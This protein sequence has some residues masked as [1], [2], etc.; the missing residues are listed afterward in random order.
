[1]K[2]TIVGA[3]T[4]IDY[5][6]WKPFMEWD[7]PTHWTAWNAYGAG[8]DEILFR[9]KADGTYLRYHNDI[10]GNVTALL[11]MN[12]YGL[13]HYTYDAFGSP[14]VTNWDGTNSRKYSNYGN[15]FMFQ[16]REYF[17]E[18]GIYDYRNRFYHPSIG[19]FLQTDPK[20]FDAGDMNLF[21]YC[22]DDPV[23]KSDPMGLDFE[24]RNGSVA[25][26]ASF[27]TAIS[28]ISHDSQMAGYIGV[29]RQ[30]NI[31]IFF[32]HDF[33]N[34]IG[35]KNELKF[36]P[37]HG[38][39]LT[40]G[41]QSPALILA[42]EFKHLYDQITNRK[43]YDHNLA[44]GVKRLGPNEPTATNA[45]ERSAIAAEK[46][47]AQTPGI[48]EPYREPSDYE[49]RYQKVP[50]DSV[51]QHTEQVPVKQIDSLIPRYLPKTGQ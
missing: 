44:M 47:T 42:H 36:D 48:N 5:D 51:T 13:E 18:L 15:R 10:H 23:D 17:Y 46:H 38:Q 11:D 3:I 49:K 40:K 8:Q 7:S 16:G 19:L 43:V 6:G 25:D 27:N 9:G 12:G 4:A 24:F 28:Y 30:Q 32:N 39:M 20:G 35:S 21:R 26:Q 29:I 2:R 41:L 1:L 22:G 50:V 31:P 34:G 37:T 14:S 45:N 33:K